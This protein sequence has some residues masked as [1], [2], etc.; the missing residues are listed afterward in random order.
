MDTDQ[1][2]CKPTSK[3]KWGVRT[4]LWIVALRT[5][6]PWSKFRIGFWACFK[7]TGN[8]NFRPLHCLVCS[9]YEQT[10]VPWKHDALKTAAPFR[11]RIQEIST[12]QEETSIKEKKKPD[13]LIG[14]DSQQKSYSWLVHKGTRSH[15]IDTN[16][17]FIYK[18]LHLLSV[19][20]IPIGFLY[21]RCVMFFRARLTVFGLFPFLYHNGTLLFKLYVDQTRSLSLIE[22]PGLL[23]D[24]SW[25]MFIRV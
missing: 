22:G 2:G 18:H 3:V 23:I 20:G 12:N 1:H 8:I 19:L 10:N 16:I 9:Y 15:H 13:L 24:N 5:W 6:S 21:F 14:Q 4:L 17:F 25:C 7:W 11:L